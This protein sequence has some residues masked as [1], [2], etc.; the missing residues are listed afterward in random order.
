[1]IGKE[2]SKGQKEGEKERNFKKRKSG[3][4]GGPQT[5]GEDLAFQL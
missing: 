5:C 1:M 2:R 4:K 3:L